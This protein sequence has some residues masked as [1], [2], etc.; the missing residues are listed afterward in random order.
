[1]YTLKDFGESTLEMDE[2]SNSKIDTHPV[3]VALV[4][5]Y[6]TDGEIEPTRYE[7]EGWFSDPVFGVQWWFE[8]IGEDMVGMEIPEWTIDSQERRER[9]GWPTIDIAAYGDNGDGGRDQ[10]IQGK[11]IIG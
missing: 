8:Y 4:F 6:I 10:V 1:M 2:K 9:R 7:R 11:I 5:H 3:K